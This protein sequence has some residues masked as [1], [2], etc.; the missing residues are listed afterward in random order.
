MLHSCRLGTQVCIE[1]G[2][3]PRACSH[4]PTL[5]LALRSFPAMM[6]LSLVCVRKPVHTCALTRSHALSRA[7]TRSHALSRAPCSFVH[8]LVHSFAHQV[9]PLWFKTM[10]PRLDAL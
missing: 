10:D 8:S 7:L 1:T 4:A 3:H 9:P 5:T 6:L 2:H